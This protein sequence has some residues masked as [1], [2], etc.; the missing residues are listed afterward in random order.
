MNCTKYF[1]LIASRPTVRSWV[2]V[3]L[4]FF[5]F[6]PVVCYSDLNEPIKPVPLS[7]PYDKNLASLGQKLFSD[8]NLSNDRSVSCSSCHILGDGGDDGKRFSTGSKDTLGTINSPTVFNT[9]FNFKHTWSGQFDDLKEQV[10]MPIQEDH[11]MGSTWPGLIARLYEDKDYPDMF[12]RIFEGSI[13]RDHVKKAIAEFQSS[14]I[15]P[16]APFDKYLS[17][18]SSAINQLEKDGYTYFKKYGCIS[19]HQGIS[20][21]GNMFQLFGVINNYF[22]ERGE[23]IRKS[24]LGRYNVTG[25]EQDKHVFKVPSLRMVEHTAPYFHDGSM[26]T[27]KEAVDAMFRYQLGRSAPEE[28]K[29]AIVAFLRTLDGI[30]QGE[31]L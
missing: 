7:V 6:Y 24:D 11:E 4:T 8:K 29:E 16:N 19:C 27:L 10:D 18:D 5:S 13:K 20:V 14:L 17:G 2:I 31:N 1:F 9:R 21:G 28:H 22:Q 15:T 25:R 26:K 30:P 3:T 23:D 12:K